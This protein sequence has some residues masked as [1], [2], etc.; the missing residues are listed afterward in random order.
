MQFKVS[1]LS[2]NFSIGLLSVLFFPIASHALEIQTVPN[3]RETNGGWVTDMA[4]ILSD[5]T[6]AKINRTISQLEA[7]NGTEIAVVTVP[8]TAPADSP[9]AFTTALFNDWGI[10]K[11]GEDN[12]V[13]LLVSVGDRR[14][15][16][17]TGYGIEPILPDRN[18]SQ[19]IE[20]HIVPKFKAGNMDGGV[21]AG[22]QALVT[23][24]D[25]TTLD[26]TPQR[27]SPF[28]LWQLFGSGVTLVA[29]GWFVKYKIDRRPQYL[30]SEGRSRS[31]HQKRHETKAAV[32]CK[33]C[34]SPMV[35]LSPDILSARLTLP[36][37]TARELNSVEFAG[38]H[39][40]HCQAPLP[41]GKFHL[42][43]YVNPFTRYEEC[44]HCQELTVE[45]LSTVVEQPTYS[46]HGQCC[47][48]WEC[49]CCD[50]K[51]QEY[52]TIPR[53]VR[54]S[55]SS[56]TRRPS[57]RNSS[58]SSS[59]SSSYSS[60]SSSSSSCSGGSS[61]SF[62]GGESGGGGAGGDW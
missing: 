7:K 62:G 40:Y 35:E 48:T 17:E 56:S 25:T 49:Y 44:P 29:A 13:L 47:T 41:Q 38:W 57:S 45:R 32:R 28:S 51:T 58:S 20:T 42:R 46:Q 43:A 55:P 12:G 1:S 52:A 22:T 39:C 8:E 60:S 16:I 26:T 61:S 30:P 21:F 37:K 23:A 14:V 59:S 33:T 27:N 4:D 24:L 50:Y 5:E 15:E 53:L 34:R 9:K 2:R 54:Q 36:Q 3:P 18:V 19:I 10:G 6:E 11:Q 31:N